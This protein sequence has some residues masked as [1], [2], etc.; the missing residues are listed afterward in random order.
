MSAVGSIMTMA[1]KIAVARAEGILRHWPCNRWCYHRCKNS[2]DMFQNGF[3]VVKDILMGVGI[4]LAAVGAVI[5]GA[6]ALVASVVAAIIFAV[7]NLVIVIK[8]H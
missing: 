6:P 8:E 1:P 7:A 3:S 4:A 2:I 5:L